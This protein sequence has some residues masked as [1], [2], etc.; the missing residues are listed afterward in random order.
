MC[1]IFD[2]NG[3][4]DVGY[5][6]FLVYHVRLQHTSVNLYRFGWIFFSCVC[7]KPI[8]GHV[9]GSNIQFRDVKVPIFFPRYKL[10]YTHACA[11]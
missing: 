6:L 2:V 7:S 3:V 4:V 10:Y 5:F 9:F 1:C 8:R 11:V